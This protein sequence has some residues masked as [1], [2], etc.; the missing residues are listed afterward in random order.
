MSLLA[1]GYSIIEVC[2]FSKDEF[3]GY[4]FKVN[5]LTMPVHLSALVLCVHYFKPEMNVLE[6][7]CIL[8]P[9][10]ALVFMKYRP[11]VEALHYFINNRLKAVGSQFVL[12]LAAGIFSAGIK[13]EH[14]FFLS[15]K[16]LPEHFESNRYVLRTGLLE[17]RS[18]FGLKIVNYEFLKTI[19]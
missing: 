16:Y 4:P 6:I 8:S 5:T 1:I 18:Y 15:G 13:D 17:S 3:S 9:A 2:Y 11:R 10:G 7:I 14:C 19:T 12:F